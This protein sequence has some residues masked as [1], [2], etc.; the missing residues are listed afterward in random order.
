MKVCIQ[1]S[2]ESDRGETECIEE[3]AQFERGE[4]RP[5]ALGLTLAEAKALLQGVQ[6]SIVA[7]QT[8]TYLE[9]HRPCPAYQVPR[10]CKG[11]HQ[12]VYR[13]VYGW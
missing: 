1:V 8:T 9:T 12:L 10:R 3:E 7:E 2:I 13:T 6:R 11:H 5:E 4:L